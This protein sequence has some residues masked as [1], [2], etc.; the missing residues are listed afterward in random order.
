MHPISVEIRY[1]LLKNILE[2]ILNN[3]YKNAF[4]VA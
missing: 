1:F 4:I 2:N 3:I